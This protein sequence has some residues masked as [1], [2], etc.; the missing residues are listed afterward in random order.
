MLF[1]SA[2]HKRKMPRLLELF[3]GTGSVGK[4]WEGEV[5]SVDVAGAEPTHRCDILEWDPTIYPPRP[6]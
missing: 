2:V 4:A 3:S 1:I 5:I 6:F